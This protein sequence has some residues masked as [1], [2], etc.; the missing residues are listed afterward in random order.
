MSLSIDRKLIRS[1]KFSGIKFLPLQ[2]HLDVLENGQCC[3]R[4]NATTKKQ[5][6]W[7]SVLAFLVE[8]NFLEVKYFQFPEA[9]FDSTCHCDRSPLV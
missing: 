8:N 9:R 5:S 1:L 3:G 4:G 6:G 2:V 7:W